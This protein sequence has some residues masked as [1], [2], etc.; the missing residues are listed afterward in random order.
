MTLAR[1]VVVAP[2]ELADGF[3]LTGV[4]VEQAESPPEAERLVRDLVAGGESGV[5][6]VYRPLF[7]GFDEDLQRRLKAS[8]S[9]V[10]VELP[11]GVGV[12]PDDLRRSRLAERLQR[13]IGYHVTFGEDET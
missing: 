8:V 7:D 13:A 5:I 11:T 9:P 4:A 2:E 6:A 3:R 1:L 10:V 12:E